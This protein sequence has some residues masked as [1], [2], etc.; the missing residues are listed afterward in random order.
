MNAFEVSSTYRQFDEVL[1]LR[2]SSDP[3]ARSILVR[4][5]QTVERYRGGGAFRRLEQG[6]AR[7]SVLLRTSD[8]AWD[9]TPADDLAIHA[10]MGTVIAAECTRGALERL[11]RDPAVISIE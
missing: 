8:P 1:Q 9:P 7:V 2:Q 5:Q 4:L 10:R 11:L 3:A 6:Q